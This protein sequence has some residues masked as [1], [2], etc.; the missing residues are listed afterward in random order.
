MN[1]NF[2]IQRRFFLT[3]HFALFEV[4][5][6]IDGLVSRVIAFLDGLEKEA[7]QE[8]VL[9]SALYSIVSDSVGFHVHMITN[10]LPAH[11]FDTSRN[12]IEN[13]RIKRN[14]I[15][16]LLVDNWFVI[17]DKIKGIKFITRTPEKVEKYIRKQPKRGQDIVFVGEYT[18]RKIEPVHS[19]VKSQFYYTASKILYRPNLTNSL[20]LSRQL[21]ISYLLL[22]F[23]ISISIILLTLF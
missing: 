13:K 5:N 14:T 10:W 15:I 20:H 6:S 9:L 4:P 17:D 22:A 8:N 7:R 3:F 11:N 21:M 12:R 16:D 2:S 23:L 18:A 19:V 1:S